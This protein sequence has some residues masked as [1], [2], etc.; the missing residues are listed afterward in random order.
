M[1]GAFSFTCDSNHGN[2]R[3]KEAGRRAAPASASLPGRRE[4]LPAPSRSARRNRAASAGDEGHTRH[5]C[6][7]PFVC[8]E[9]QRLDTHWRE[10]ISSALLSFPHWERVVSQTGKGARLALTSPFPNVQKHPWVGHPSPCQTAE[11]SEPIPLQLGL[12][13]G[14]CPPP[15]LPEAGPQ[16][17]EAQTE[18]RLLPHSDPRCSDRKGPEWV[19]TQPPG[20]AAEL[21]GG[22]G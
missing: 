17:L 10:F 13:L 8:A 1:G 5:L 15:P 19:V 4:P 12:T 3:D 16:A 2:G 11:V 6:Q 18:N 7:S 14:P 20:R 21:P 9:R 22:T